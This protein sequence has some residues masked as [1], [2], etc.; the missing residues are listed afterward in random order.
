MRLDAAVR[1]MN[2]EQ[3][4]GRQNWTHQAGWM[5]VERIGKRV[6]WKGER[7]VGQSLLICPCLVPRRP[8][9]LARLRTNG[10]WL[11]MDVN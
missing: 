8:D 7:A 2:E 6:D 5:D 3:L 4:R 9:R 1:T 10:C 11:Q